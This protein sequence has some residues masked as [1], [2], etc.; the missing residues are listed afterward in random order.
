MIDLIQI[1]LGKNARKK[2]NMLAENQI[3]RVL[4]QCKKVAG[5][6]NEG[7]VTDF[8][9]NDYYINIGWIEALNLVLERNTQHISN[10]P[11]A[12]LGDG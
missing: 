8:R 3:R 10:E 1:N 9:D 4:A 7:S 11:L 6:Y 2:D 5:S 12:H